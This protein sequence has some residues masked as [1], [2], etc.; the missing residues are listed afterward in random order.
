ARIGDYLGIADKKERVLGL[1]SLTSDHPIALGTASGVVKRVAPGA[2]PAKPD[3]EV[4][5][6]KLGDEVIGVAQGPDSDEL[7]IV[8]TDARLLHFPASA[9]RPQ[10]TAAGGMAGINLA[11]AAAVLFFGAVDPSADVVVA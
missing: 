11:S 3:F 6:L 10:G 2:W 9:V 1:V 4:I 7:V 8:T 5:A